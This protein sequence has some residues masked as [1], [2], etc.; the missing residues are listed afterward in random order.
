MTMCPSRCLHQSASV[1]S[2]SGW[3]GVLHGMVSIS[4]LWSLRKCFTLLRRAQY[5]NVHIAFSLS[6]SNS[7]LTFQAKVVLV[8]SPLHCW[9]R[10]GMCSCHIHSTVTCCISSRLPWLCD[11]TMLQFM[12]LEHLRPWDSCRYHNLLRLRHRLVSRDS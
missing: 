6:L 11:I 12:V 3:S 7:G 10:S 9:D 1:R 5:L 2:C 4:I 8:S